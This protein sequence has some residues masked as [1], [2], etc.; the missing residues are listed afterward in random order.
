[1]ISA[2]KQ[3]VTRDLQ[4]ELL[5]LVDQVNE[6]LN[7]KGFDFAVKE[8]VLQEGL[9]ASLTDD[10]GWFCESDCDENGANCRV[11]CGIRCTG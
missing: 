3:G 1:M 4:S 11:H 5:K 9:T 8:I 10:C 2:E 6:E 7:R